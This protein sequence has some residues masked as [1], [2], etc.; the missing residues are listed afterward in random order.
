M[1]KAFLIAVLGVLFGFSPKPSSAQAQRAFGFCSIGGIAATVS[2]LV[3]FPDV[4]ASYPSCTVTVNI[5][6]GGLATLFSDSALSVPLANPFTANTNG[7]WFF[8]AV[9]GRYDIQLS[10][11][12]FG[13]P[14]T[15]GDYLL[16]SGSGVGNIVGCTTTGGVVYQN[17]TT[18]TGTCGANQ[19]ADSSGDLNLINPTAAT[20]SVSQSSPL[21]KLAGTC[22]NGSAYQAD[23]YTFQNVVPNGS[24]QGGTMT[25]I[26]SGCNVPFNGVSFGGTISAN[27][28]KANTNFSSP[29]IL[30]NDQIFDGSAITLSSVANAVGSLATYTGPSATAIAVSGMYATVTGFSTGANNGRFKVSSSTPTTLVLY[31]SSAV[32][33]THA[34][35]A[36]LDTSYVLS[37]ASTTL[38]GT[39]GTTTPAF[40]LRGSTFKVKLLNNVAPSGINEVDTMDANATDAGYKYVVNDPT[41]GNHGLEIGGISDGTGAAP[42]FLNLG[43]FDSA[44]EIK[45]SSPTGVAIKTGVGSGLCILGTTSAQGCLTDNATSTLLTVSIPLEVNGPARSGSAVTSA[46]ATATGGFGCT[47]SASTGWTPTA[48]QDYMRCD[49][50]SHTLVCSQNGAAE[51]GCGSGGGGI[52]GLTTG[53]IA[54][55]A[56][57]TTITNSLLDEGITTANVLTSTHTRGITA[58]DLAIGTPGSNCVA[59]T[60]GPLCSKEG[61]GPTPAAGI[62]MLYADA[63]HAWGCSINN[64]ATTLGCSFLGPV[65]SSVSFVTGT[66]AT[67]CG[68]TA[69]G[70]VCLTE[71]TSTGYTPTAGFDYMRGDSTAHAYLCSMNGSA[72]GLG[73]AFQGLI[74]QTNIIVDKTM[75]FNPT[76]MSAQSANSAVAITGM[77]FPV[78]ASKQYKLDCNLYM[79]FVASATVKFSL[80]GTG[81]LTLG[82]ID[83]DGP[84]NAGSYQDINGIGGTTW[85][86]GSPLATGVS[87]AP[88]GVNIPVH[89][90][91]AFVTNTSGTVTVNTY[92]NGT[93]NITVLGASVC[94]M[95]QAN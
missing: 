27:I 64:G 44:N 78:A 56:S 4:N 38:Q 77:S 86:S 89:L 66:G 52:S 87:N 43:V 74:N 68:A 29:S 57:A 95:F 5:T 8:Y 84:L 49:S 65:T 55:A 1:K 33:E 71:G 51:A 13:S 69:V 22:W 9:N 18:N 48:G 90:K 80:I 47:E 11:A 59:G 45:L 39:G 54:K 79:T 70:G 31:N 28:V 81:T 60:G 7:Y 76:N 61:T 2:G 6:G 26:Y 75:G 30:N 93:N 92:G 21:L 72:D 12:G 37:G 23:Y 42:A 17:G 40:G 19:T 58:V 32:S 3:V 50:A 94:Q 41:T 73:C 53:F 91:A 88:G 25:L 16:G 46:G 36:T 67:P 83:A 63:S 15:L 24:G 20:S 35:T 85:T 14:F 82:N 10:G 34:A 62:D